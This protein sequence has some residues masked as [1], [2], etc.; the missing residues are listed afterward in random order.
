M[1]KL[2]FEH[3]VA[4]LDH[5]R[6]R[7]L[8]HDLFLFPV[9]DLSHF[10]AQVDYPGCASASYCLG[11][12]S[13]RRWPDYASSCPAC[14]HRELKTGCHLGEDLHDL[15]LVPL[16]GRDDCHAPH[17]ATCHRLY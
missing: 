6:E 8:C 5:Q 1:L 7:H 10:L 9:V 12:V 16:L 4:P 17:Q 2:E 11:D 15:A 3:S 14:S 13:R